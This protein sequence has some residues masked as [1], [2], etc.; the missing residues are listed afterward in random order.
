MLED[1]DTK[2]TKIQPLIQRGHQETHNYFFTKTFTFEFHVLVDSNTVSP[3]LEIFE[4]SL[5]H[6]PSQL[7]FHPLPSLF[8]SACKNSLILCPPLQSC[9]YWLGLHFVIFLLNYCSSLLIVF[10]A[11]KSSP[12]LPAHPGPFIPRVALWKQRSYHI[13]LPFSNLF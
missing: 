1:G 2:V 6:F 5:T 8:D 13:T 9:C 12:L 10:S 7:A 3:K 11:F 4:L